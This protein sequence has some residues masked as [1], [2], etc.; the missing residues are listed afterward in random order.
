MVPFQSEKNINA[1]ERVQR[2]FTEHIDGMH[3]LHNL[4]YAERLKSLRSTLFKENG[5][6]ISYG[7]LHV[8]DT[9]KKS[10]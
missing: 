4:S 8:E 1:I 3:K 9:G 6:D 7:H 10:A 5:T 2:V